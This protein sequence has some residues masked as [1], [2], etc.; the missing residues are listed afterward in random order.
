MTP[1]RRKPPTKKKPPFLKGLKPVDSYYAHVE[2]FEVESDTKE[3]EQV[4]FITR[5]KKK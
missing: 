4:M 2:V 1:K 3:T 5:A